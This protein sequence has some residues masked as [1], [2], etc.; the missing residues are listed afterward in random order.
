[1][2]KT[3]LYRDTESGAIFT[4]EEL[5]DAYHIYINSGAE[6]FNEYISNCTSKDGFL[7]E[8]K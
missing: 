8:I 4:R 1:M 7:E 3:I 5:L 2:T 6:S